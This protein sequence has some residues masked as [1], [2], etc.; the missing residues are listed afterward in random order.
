MR[1]TKNIRKAPP[2]IR[3]L[4]WDTQPLVSP[5]IIH[6]PNV[7]NNRT[8]STC[9]AF[10]R[11]EYFDFEIPTWTHAWEEMHLFSRFPAPTLWCY[12]FLNS[13][14]PREGNPKGTRRNN[15]VIMTSM[16]RRDVVLTSQW[17]CFASCVGTFV[18]V[19]CDDNVLSVC[20][21]WS[22]VSSNHSHLA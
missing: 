3:N 15:N 22:L 1:C 4:S 12:I 18:W 8:I 9:H 16:R 11:V 17:R 7:S 20:S 13:L 6:F 21:N 14:K 10:T 19:V 5:I 2:V